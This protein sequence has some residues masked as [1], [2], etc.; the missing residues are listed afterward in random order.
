MSIQIELNNDQAWALAQLFKRAGISDYRPLAAS[1]AEAQE[2]QEA[3]ERMRA[4]LA[5]Q[6]IAPR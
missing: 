5:E 3:G 4:A 2:M 6:G 1:D